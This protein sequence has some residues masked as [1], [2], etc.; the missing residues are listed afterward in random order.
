MGQCGN[1]GPSL[2]GEQRGGP[3]YLSTLHR[4]A[5]PRRAG[6]EQSLGLPPT[7]WE[8]RTETPLGRQNGPAAAP[9]RQNV[10]MEID[11][12]AKVHPWPH[13]LLHGRTYSPPKPD[14]I[15]GSIWTA[16]TAL[17]LSVLPHSDEAKGALAEI[18]LPA[19]TRLRHE[20]TRE[21]GDTV[22]SSAIGAHLRLQVLDGPHAGRCVQVLTGDRDRESPAEALAVQL[23]G[24]SR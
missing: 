20:S 11:W 14:D 24:L 5:I 23:R 2:W 21:N 12:C 4:S 7:L 13:D 3:G 22:T 6:R 17:R 15:T 9:V 1:P 10:G 18:I 16:D 19:G 8:R